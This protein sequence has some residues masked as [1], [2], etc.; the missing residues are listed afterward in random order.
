MFAW[1]PNSSFNTKRYSAANVQLSGSKITWTF[2]VHGPQRRTA[3]DSIRWAANFGI[4]TWL[5]LM[6]M[7][8]LNNNLDFTIIIR[9]SGLNHDMKMSSVYGIKFWNLRARSK[10]QVG[11]KTDDFF[12]FPPTQIQIKLLPSCT[13]NV[14]WSLSGSDWA[15]G[16]V[17][18]SSRPETEQTQWWPHDGLPHF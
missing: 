4:S 17:A 18:S 6:E 5:T 3:T 16:A 14:T 15:V 7:T 10:P 9:L 1:S 8:L 13:I 12:P 2:Y 11:R